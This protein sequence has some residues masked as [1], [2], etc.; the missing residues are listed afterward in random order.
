KLGVLA[1]DRGLMSPDQVEETHQAQTRMDNRFG[2]VAV[3]MGYLTALQT[4]ELLTL[5]QSAHLALGQAL[6]DLNILTYDT[7]AAALN[8]YKATFS[9]TDDQFDRITHGDIDTLLKA[10]L[11]KD[12]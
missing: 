11:L 8:Q 2:E 12:E 1:I 4:D 9:L 6:V 10:V 3:K 7:F 5:Q